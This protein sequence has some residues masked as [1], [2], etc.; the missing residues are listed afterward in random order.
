LPR[1]H[2]RKTEARFPPLVTRWIWADQFERLVRLC[3]DLVAPW[4]RDTCRGVGKRCGSKIVRRFLLLRQERAKRGR[5]G[6]PGFGPERTS[7]ASQP[8]PLGIGENLLDIGMW[9]Q[10]SGPAVASLRHAPKLPLVVSVDCLRAETGR[11]DPWW[12]GL[13]PPMTQMVH[14][15][16]G[17]QWG[18]PVVGAVEGLAVIWPR[19]PQCG[20]SS[21]R[22]GAS[23]YRILQ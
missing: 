18:R 3:H 14:C 12:R 11:V 10:G 2:E 15:P 20:N 7:L 6:A 22:S 5:S 13:G 9:H 16:W 21:R 19:R 17:D 1:S 4:E 8:D 23:C